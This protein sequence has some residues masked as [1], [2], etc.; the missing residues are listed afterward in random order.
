MHT[1][2]HLGPVCVAAN[3]GECGKRSNGMHVV[4][5]NNCRRGLILV[6]KMYYVELVGR[7]KIVRLLEW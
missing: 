1:H 6:Y 5:H 2:T 7:L 4:W 3:C